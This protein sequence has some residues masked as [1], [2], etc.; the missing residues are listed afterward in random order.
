MGHQIVKQ[1]NGR[2]CIFNSVIDSIIKYDMS[3]DEIVEEWTRQARKEIKKEVEEICEKLDN[4]EKP[5]LKFT[6]TYNECIDIIIHEHG[7]DLGNKI[8]L[9]IESD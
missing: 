6:K 9:L 2:Y 1:P 7:S 8:K 4:G 3:A 5:Y